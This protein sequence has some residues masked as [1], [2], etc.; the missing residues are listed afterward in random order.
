MFVAVY[1][2]GKHVYPMLIFPSVDF[3][4]HGLTGVFT[5]STGSGN[6][7]HWSYDRLFLKYLKHL[8]ACETPF[9]EDSVDFKQP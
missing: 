9:K 7:A 5:A 2:I 4:N 1:A 3:K 8:I 6:P